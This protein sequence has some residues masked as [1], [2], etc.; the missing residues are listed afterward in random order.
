V[1]LG[2]R[3]NGWRYQTALPYRWGRSM[4]DGQSRPHPREADTAGHFGNKTISYKP[5]KSG[6]S[7]YWLY[8]LK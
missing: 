4:A 5:I 2:S 1:K 7:V 3:N 6:V 8:S